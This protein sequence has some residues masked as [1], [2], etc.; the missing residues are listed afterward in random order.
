MYDDDVFMYV[1]LPKQISTPTNETLN[2]DWH[3]TAV[4]KNLAVSGGLYFRRNFFAPLSPVRGPVWPQYFRQQDPTPTFLELRV[5]ELDHCNPLDFL[6]W[7][8]SSHRG[9]PYPCL[10]AGRPPDPHQGLGSQIRTCTVICTGCEAVKIGGAKKNFWNTALPKPQSFWE[11]L[12][13]SLVFFTTVKIFHK[14]GMVD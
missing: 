9:L 6:A 14:Y 7:G 10:A 2:C 5:W 12:Y 1:S 13:I 3:L 11:Q 4:P 8:R